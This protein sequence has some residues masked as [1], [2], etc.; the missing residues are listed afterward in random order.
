MKK[1]LIFMNEKEDILTLKEA[2]GY[3]KIGRNKLLELAQKGEVP[4]KRI[5]KAWRFS[6]SQLRDYVENI[7]D[8]VNKSAKQ[9]KSLFAT[10]KGGK[11]KA[12]GEALPQESSS[13][14][15]LNFDEF[16][17]IVNKKNK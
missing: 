2:M 15:N 12:L 3:L 9:E 1:Q 7:S 6:R 13:K 5:G 16:I 4:A 14:G 11:K 10:N 8:G 17:K